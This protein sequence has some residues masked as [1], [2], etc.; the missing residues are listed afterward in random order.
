MPYS[1]FIYPVVK[2]RIIHTAFQSSPFEGLFKPVS[3]CV[4]VRLRPWNGLYHVLKQCLSHDRKIIFG[5][6]L[7]MFSALRK[8]LI[9]RVFASDRESARKFA[10]NK[11]GRT[12]NSDEKNAGRWKYESTPYRIPSGGKQQHRYRIET[13]TFSIEINLHEIYTAPKSV[14]IPQIFI[15]YI[16]NTLPPSYVLLPSSS[17]KPCLNVACYAFDREVLQIIRQ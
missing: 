9:S 15:S 16:V 5:C 7:L 11:R 13:A 10:K 1:L 4:M 3:G 17:P 14:I 8:P 12:E 2:C 6:K